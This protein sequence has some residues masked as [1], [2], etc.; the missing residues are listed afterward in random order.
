MTRNRQILVIFT[1]VLISILLLIEP[2]ML[3]AAPHPRSA[4]PQTIGD[5]PTVRLNE[6]APAALPGQ[7]AWIEIAIESETYLIFLPVVMRNS[8]GTIFLPDMASALRVSAPRQHS[9]DLSG[10]H[11]RAGDGHTYAIPETLP[12]VSGNALL[13]IVLGEGTDDLDFSDGVATLYASELPTD[14]FVAEGSHVGLYNSDVITSPNIVDFVA[15]GEDPGEAAAHAVEAGIWS[16]GRYHYFDGGFGVGIS[17]GPARPNDSLGR[18]RR[19]WTSYFAADSSRGQP[20]NPPRPLHSTIAD[21]AILDRSTFRLA[22][23]PVEAPEGEIHYEFELATTPAFTDTLFHVITEN[24]GWEPPTPLPTDIITFYWRVRTVG[25]NGEYSPYLG[26]FHTGAQNILAPPVT[27]LSDDEYRIQRKDTTMLDLGGPRNFSGTVLIGGLVRFDITNNFRDRW[28]GPH[29]F[30]DTLNPSY[31]GNGMDNW[32]CVRAS[33]AMMNAYYGGNLSQDRISYFHFE[34]WDGANPPAQK[35]IPE[36]DLG[37]RSGIPRYSMQEAVLE[38]A[39]GTDVTG[40]SY[41]PQRPASENY[42]CPHPGNPPRMAWSEI[43][44]LI[45]AGKPFMSINLNN[46]HARVVDGYRVSGTGEQQVRILDPVPAVCTPGNQTCDGRRWEAYETFR[47][48]NERIYYVTNNAQVNA[49]NDEADL[50]KDFDSDGVNNF[51]EIRRFGTSPWNMD[52]DGDWVYDKEDIAEY[53][54]DA[55]GAYFKRLAD[56]PFWL[57]PTPLP[58]PWMDTL[59]KE[60]DWD[61]DNDGVPDGCE[62]INFNGIFEPWLG[63]SNNFNPNSTRVCPVWLLIWEPPNTQPVYVGAINNP[64]KFKVLLTL[65]L[66]PSYP[67]PYPTYNKNQFSV[68]V[69]GRNAPVHSMLQNGLLVE[70]WVQ[71]PTQL[72]AGVY[73]LEVMFNNAGWLQTETKPNVVKYSPLSF[74]N[75]FT[76]FD[77]SNNNLD[78]LA[79]AQLATKVF[80][81]QWQIGDALGFGTFGNGSATVDVPLGMILSD[82]RRISETFAAIDGL[83]PRGEGALGSALLQA[84]DQL[85]RNGDPADEWAIVILSAGQPTAG[86][87]PSGF[88]RETFGARDASPLG[89]LTGVFSPTAL[90]AV[91]AEEGPGSWL[92]GL[93]TLTGA[94]SG[95]LNALPPAH[96]GLP[97]ILG[98]RLAGA[99]KHTAEQV[100]GEQRL[101]EAS[102]LISATARFTYPVHLDEATTLAFTAVFS[103]TG[104]G[105]LEVFRPD[106]SQIDP[107]N[108]PDAEHRQDALFEHVRISAP[109]S[110]TWEVVIK[111][112]D[113]A[114]AVAEYLVVASADTQLMLTPGE[115]WFGSGLASGRHGLEPFV[116]RAALHDTEPVTGA[117]VHAHVFF[118]D[119]SLG[120]TLPLH[121]DG[122]AADGVYGSE[123]FTPTQ[124]GAHILHFIA[125]GTDNAGQPFT[126]YAWRTFFHQKPLAYVHDMQADGADFAGFREV[127]AVLGI[128]LI[129]INTGWVSATTWSG[130][131]AILIDPNSKIPS[132]LQ[133]VLEDSNLPIIGLGTGGYALFDD[134]GLQ[135]GTNGSE[136]ALQMATTP[137]DGG[138]SVWST[139][140]PLDGTAPYTVYT[141]TTGIHLNLGSAPLPGV[142]LIGLDP[143]TGDVNIAQESGRYLLWGFQAGPDMMTE[144]GRRVFSNLIAWFLG[145]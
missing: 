57:E 13:V 26:P 138:A 46:A 91:G 77:T 124:T 113:P 80:V 32:Y 40:V 34:E 145:L 9:V 7:P 61:N 93:Q 82:T 140:F 107:N 109:V 111:S 11:I 125:T 79:A 31:R 63:E 20:N 50:W 5:G 92:N 127:L 101:L 59:R 58:F 36:N 72:N 86:P 35:G 90:F 62:D 53:V 99:Y 97:A 87:H 68:R 10:W 78:T 74:Q 49:R 54:F 116:I 96:P 103:E 136:G 144:T 105:A 128:P 12:S 37:Y 141:A 135:I 51:D 27:L 114:G 73:G 48:D 67:D 60:V 84:Q 118:P 102:G 23:S 33:T 70:L 121:D 3:E 143:D 129:P 2:A 18:W 104:I 16:A 47:D 6:V 71:A 98:N 30:G 24:P 8:I 112:I 95:A 66:P 14:T 75:T 29:V 119:G 108:D 69:N 55:S 76:L 28:D 83:T 94:S 17:A 38:W 52:T 126:R 88:I 64:G 120:A 65:T 15:W 130:Y 41:C 134:L 42:T 106:G 1:L 132:P 39:L 85:D 56:L 4:Q 117:T 142:T 115:S 25:R 44:A 137:F 110:G 81:S 22:W 19:D 133:A 89:A 139:P 43:I 45:N 122:A 131:A 123:I 21:G 100:R